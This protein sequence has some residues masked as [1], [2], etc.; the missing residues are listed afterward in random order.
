[1]KKL[2]L[3]LTALT[4]IASLAL[5]ACDSGTG[6]K[7]TDAK[8]E[9]TTVAAS[10]NGTEAPT[11]SET[12]AATEST[13]ATYTVKVVDQDGNPV[14]KAFVQM[15]NDGTCFLPK[16]TD[17]TGSASFQQDPAST[18]QAKLS[19]LPEGYTGDTESYF[20]FEDGSV[21]ITVTKD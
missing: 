21:T 13:L 12:V 7:E 10:T 6:D 14:E 20:D 3:F 11:E 16:S 18:Y 4:L 17:A 9:S 8:T 5:T 1:M 19:K 2:I 15:C